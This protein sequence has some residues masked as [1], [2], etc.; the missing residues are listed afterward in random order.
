MQD[1][2]DNW[3]GRVSSNSPE[4]SDVKYINCNIWSRHV[5]LTP[6]SQPLSYT[7]HITRLVINT[8]VA[9]GRGSS[10]CVLYIQ[11]SVAGS[12][13]NSLQSLRTRHTRAILDASSSANP[14]SSASQTFPT[15]SHNDSTTCIMKRKADELDAGMNWRSWSPSSISSASANDSPDHKHHGTVPWSSVATHYTGG[16]EYL[17]FRTR[18]RIRD[19]RPDIKAIHENTLA[20]LFNAQRQHQT[21]ESVS[22]PATRHE[23]QSGST[24]VVPPTSDHLAQRNLHSFFAFPD[25]QE[26]AKYEDPHMQY[27]EDEVSLLCEDCGTSLIGSHASP[28]HGSEMMDVDQVQPSFIDQDF[29]CVTCGRRVCD[30]C[31]V[32]GNQRVCLQSRCQLEADFPY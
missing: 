20:K 16:N 22:Q 9:L 3:P 30:M 24:H 28:N 10:W 13:P 19:N 17:N 8:K 18:K 4:F 2:A 1:Q 7:P 5:T 32:R 27:V 11:A 31:A 14:L 25:R 15:R 21:P 29:D 26:N 12:E 23:H 6:S